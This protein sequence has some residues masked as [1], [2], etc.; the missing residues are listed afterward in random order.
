[1]KQAVRSSFAPAQIAAGG[2]GWF[3]AQGRIVSKPAL[4]GWLH[5]T[6][7]NE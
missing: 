3:Q 1:M 2:W 4:E 5:L 7:A 6:I